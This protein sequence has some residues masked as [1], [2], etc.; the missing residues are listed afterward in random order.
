MYRPTLVAAPAALPVTLAAAKTHCRVDASDEDDLITALIAAATDY[1]DGWAG[2]LGRCIVAQSWQ[3][4]SDGFERIMRLPLAPV[5]AIT[6]VKYLDTAG[7]EQTVA[8]SNYTLHADARGAFVRFA[9]SYGFPSVKSEGP[10][11]SIVYVAG[12]ETVPPAL[13]QAILLL[14]GHWYK[15]R[16]QV[17]AGQSGALPMAVDALIAP[18]RRDLI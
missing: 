3:H 13:A 9:A 17:T 7:D 1:L 6:S 10:A 5:S 11:V 18:Y 8:S 2:I 14:V 12:Y 4:D 15:N 16:E